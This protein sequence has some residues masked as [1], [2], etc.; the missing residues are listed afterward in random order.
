V[1]KIYLA[2]CF[3]SSD[4]NTKLNTNINFILFFNAC[5]GMNIG[6]FMPVSGAAIAFTKRNT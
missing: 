1:E 3:Y 6:P 2:Y 5:Q 4:I